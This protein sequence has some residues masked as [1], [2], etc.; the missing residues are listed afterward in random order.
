MLSKIK[1]KKKRKN[2]AT[3]AFYNL[4]NLFDIYDD[5]DTLDDEYTPTGEKKWTYRKYKNKLK[6]LAEVIAKIGSDYTLRPPTLIGFAELENESVLIDLLNTKGLREFPYDY[7]HYDS[8]DDRGVDVAFAFCK[9][10]FEL[11]E[12]SKHEL[13]IYQKNGNR[14]YTRDILYVKGKLRGELMHIIVNHWPSRREGEESVRKR[15]AAAQRVH[16][17]IHTINTENENP[18]IIIMGDFNDEYNSPSIQKHLVSSQFFNPMQSLKDS[19]LGSSYYNGKW[20]LFDQIIFSV[21]FLE[22]RQGQFFFKYADVF[23]PDFLKTWKGKRKNTPHRT[24][25]GTWHQGGY[26]DHF[27]VFTQIEQH[28]RFLF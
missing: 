20:F 8:P 28:K 12:S 11:I 18:K 26:S 7:V 23:N 10:D 22:K 17:I 21:N 5:P 24:Y 14:D 2:S 6:K 13:I 15:I 3:V 9:K 19:G 4:D 27:P 1:E 16:E 25:V